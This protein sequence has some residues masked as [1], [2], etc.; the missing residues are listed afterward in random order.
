MQPYPWGRS[1]IYADVMKA[2]YKSHKRG[3]R[4]GER[5][6]FTGLHKVD[7]PHLK[8]ESPF[9]VAHMGGNAREW[10]RSSSYRLPLAVRGASYKTPVWGANL[11]LREAPT[12]L[13]LRQEDIGFRC[14]Q[15]VE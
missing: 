8:G 14:A 1:A 3:K 9:G 13:S 7:E 6:G 5:D 11:M 15:D 4:R 12:D 2:N 10:V